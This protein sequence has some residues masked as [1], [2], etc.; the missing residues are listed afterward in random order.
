MRNFPKQSP[1]IARYSVQV[2]E[3]ITKE[4][5]GLGDA[6]KSAT[7]AIGLKP[8]SGC[9]QR[10]IFLNQMLVFSGRK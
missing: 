5:I 2:P 8:C 7:S 9:E 1:G 6:F 3:F 4:E 10:A